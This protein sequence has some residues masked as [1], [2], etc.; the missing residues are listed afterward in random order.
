M[1]QVLW[2]GYNG[3][4]LSFADVAAILIYRPV[5]D[6][7]ILGSYGQVPGGVRSVIVTGD[8]RYLPARLAVDELRRRWAGWRQRQAP[9]P[10]LEQAD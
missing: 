9:L 4:S 5:L 1:Q 2:L 8:G 10:P 7:R 3:L 6:S